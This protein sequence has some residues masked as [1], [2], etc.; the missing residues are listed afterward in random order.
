MPSVAPDVAPAGRRKSEP[1]APGLAD[2]APQ[3]P[4]YF[5]APFYRQAFPGETLPARTL[6]QSFE[7]QAAG[8][9]LMDLDG[10]LAR[11]NPAFCQMLGYTR[12]ELVGASFQ[13][14]ALAEDLRLATRAMR[15][16]LL[17]AA[18]SAHIELRFQRKDGSLARIEL[19]LAL[20]PD[21]S[22][23]PA[24]FSILAL[25]VSGRD[26]TAAELPRR[27]QELESRNVEQQNHLLADP[28][29]PASELETLAGQP[30]TAPQPIPVES[31]WQPELPY[32]TLE[33]AAPQ[34]DPGAAETQWLPGMG[35]FP[36]DEEFLEVIY[37]PSPRTPGVKPVAPAV[38]RG[39]TER[40]LTGEKM[41]QHTAPLA[42]LALPRQPG[43]GVLAR[44]WE[45][46]LLRL[47]QTA[48]AVYLLLY[49][50]GIALAE[51]VTTYANPQLGLVIHGGLLV[52]IFL[53]ASI[54]AARAEQRFLFTLTLAPLIRLLSLSM[55]LLEFQFLYWYMVIGAP[56]FLS[57]W[58]VLRLT[59]FTPRQV[60][61]SLGTGLPLQIAV[62]FT[63]L[64]LGYLEFVILKPEPLVESFSLQNVWLPALILL[65]FTGFLEEMIFRGLMQQASLATIGKLGPLYISLLFAVLHIGYRSLADFVFV[66]LV[67]LYFS[68]VVSRTRSILG[69]TLAHG[70]TNITLFLVFPFWP[71]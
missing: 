8:M 28:P 21:N 55:P 41:G 19:H 42:A 46:L 58:L 18:R 2:R 49:L 71:F 38:R 23:K 22:R 20:L 39:L 4:P 29:L 61:L 56:L 53:H 50:M 68:L 64:I 63:G 51:L 44:P 43:I 1:A 25:D 6:E 26:E 31:E 32:S 34:P 70:L 52:L 69:V 10:R 35:E 7:L 16:M 33:V 17:G 11:A 3:L 9:V 47:G 67:G 12:V 66:L 15:A 48:F 65:V 62:A 54:G 45:R 36:G 57:V 40:Q 5:Q 37:L 60:G 59:G 30:A 27:I 13:Y 14:L 24:Y